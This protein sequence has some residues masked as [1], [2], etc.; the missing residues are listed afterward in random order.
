VED[1]QPPYDLKLEDFMRYF[2][3]GDP[4]HLS[5]LQELQNQLPKHLL[6]SDAEWFKTW[7]QSG[8][9][10]DPYYQN[11]IPEYFWPYKENQYY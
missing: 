4:Y 9:R 1:K 6:K 8:R 10:A 5:G 3:P 11:S 2:D 7:S